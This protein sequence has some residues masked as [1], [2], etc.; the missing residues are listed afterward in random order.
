MGAGLGAMPPEGAMGLP[1]APSGPPPGMPPVGMAKGGL[2]Q[3]FQEGSDEE[4]VTPLDEREERMPSEAAARILDPETKAALRQQFLQLMQPRPAAEIPTLEAAMARRMPQYEQLLGSRKESLQGQILLDIAQKALGYAANVDAQGRPLRGGTAARMLAAF[5]GVPGTLAAAGAEATKADQA[6][7]LAAMQAAEKDVASAEARQGRAQQAREN[8][9]LGAARSGMLIEGREDLAAREAATRER[10]LGMRLDAQDLTTRYRESVRE[11]IAAEARASR[12]RT[13]EARLDAAR[14]R[15]QEDNIYRQLSNVN[16][17]AT[18]MEIATAGFA[19]R[20]SIAEARDAAAFER[21][22]LSEATRER[23]AAENR[24]SR[25]QT[26]EARQALQSAIEFERNITR[27][28]I[29]AD[30]NAT[31]LEVSDR[32]N[33]TA[34]NIQAA[35]DSAAASRQSAELATRERIAA[36]ARASKERTTE[37]IQAAQDARQRE[38]LAAQDARAAASRQNAFDIAVLRTDATGA[39]AMDRRMAAE[40]RGNWFMPIVTDPTL[41]RAFAAGN[42]SEDNEARISAAIVEYTKPVV[43]TTRDPETGALTSTTQYRPLPQAWVNA[44][45]AR[46]MPIPSFQRESTAMPPP[47]VGEGMPGGAA[48][49][50]PA[51]AAVPPLPTMA[52]EGATAPAPAVATP[53]APAE[54]PLPSPISVAPPAPTRQSLF[55]VA[56]SMTGPINAARAAVSQIP[57]FGFV[58]V[59]DAAVRRTAMLETEALI[60]ASL[61]NSRAPIDE[62]RRL[63]A[64]LNVGPTISDVNKYR[65]DL[66]GIANTLYSEYVSAATTIRNP[67]ATPAMR[68]DARL[69]ANAT[70]KLLERVAPPIYDDATLAAVK[71]QLAPGT[72]FL[73][74]NSKGKL[75][76]L[77][78]PQR[79]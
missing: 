20:A 66:V 46:N 57:G 17:N 7:R 16:N 34:E 61:K 25:E 77:R 40:F 51:T 70:S 47:S 2:V 59:E 10:L 76:A 42:T 23:I 45:R 52:P 64:L 43:T 9:I 44:F 53:T 35:R 18:R 24:A 3:R 68:S 56:P 27:R 50:L 6:L 39:R 74:L 13:E 69:K 14:L 72:A 1:P 31:R 54:A 33:L 71:D 78:V 26:E 5:S 79:R 15:N 38:L 28:L 19:S 63:R 4:G 36:E 60:E 21:T 22:Q 48:I 29:S 55:D 8:A 12:E 32:R 30:Q 65:S 37:A 73:Y 75:E 41:A 11:R 49:P 67:D 62:Q 58:G